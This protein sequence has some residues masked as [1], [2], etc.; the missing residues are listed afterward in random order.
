MKGLQYLFFV[1]LF[2]NF[3]HGQHIAHERQRQHGVK[4]QII[5]RIFS[6]YDPSLRPPPQDGSEHTS[7]VVM[8]TLVISK[9]SFKDQMALM[10]I[11]LRQQWLDSRLSYQVDPREGVEEIKLTSDRVIWT[12]KTYFPKSKLISKDS[13]DA[14]FIVES[15]GFIR[16]KE[17]LTLE[18]SVTSTPS[19]PFSSNKE[20]TLKL[21]SK[22]HK[23]EDVAY[24]WSHAPPALKPVTVFDFAVPS[25]YTF[26]EAFAGDCVGNY[27]MGS[28]SCIYVTLH[29]DTSA[30]QSLI[31]AFFPSLLLLICSWFHFFISPTWSVPRT[32]SATVP[33]IIFSIVALFLKNHSWNKH[34]ESGFQYWLLFCIVLTFLSFLEYFLVIIFTSKRKEMHYVLPHSVQNNNPVSN[35]GEIKPTNVSVEVVSQPSPQNKCQKMLQNIDIVSRIIFP[36][37]TIVFVL[38]FSIFNYL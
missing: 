32:I 8:A 4:T 7:I 6:D 5:H 27:T 28:H 22:E 13:D 33:F 20:I 31:S 10:D 35:N 29:L 17:K 26:K 19:F 9:I 16:S 12:P 25:G 36:L 2:L 14:S 15:S 24:V 21:S 1:L 38:L 34:S 30:S 23:L 11:T 18:T 3:V 37:A